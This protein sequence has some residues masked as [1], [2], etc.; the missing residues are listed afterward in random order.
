VA[1]RAVVDDLPVLILVNLHKGTDPPKTGDEYRPDRVS[2]PPDT[3]LY[4]GIII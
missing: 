2:R 1:Q 3:I 4:Y